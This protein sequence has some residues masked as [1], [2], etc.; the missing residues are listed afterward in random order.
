MDRVRNE[1][2][3][4]R[5][6]KGRELA[7]IAVQR[8]LRWFGHAER[9]DEYRMAR[10]VMMAEVSGGRVRGRPRLGW[11]DGVKVAF[12]NRGMTVEAMVHMQLNESRFHFC[13]AP[14]SFGP[15]SRALMVITWRGVGCQMSDVNAQM[16]SIW[17]KGV[18]W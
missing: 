15:P 3:H 2:V 11:M 8:V 5:D 10:R 14:C 12:G 6:G 4:R 13:L 9:M 17:A 18:F 16:S 7:S 1:E